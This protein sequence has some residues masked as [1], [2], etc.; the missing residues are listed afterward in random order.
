[1]TTAPQPQ[2]PR[3]SWLRTL[4]FDNPMLFEATR[5][6]RRFVRT[7]GDTGRAV[8]FTVLGIL[9]IVYL[10]LLAAI[11]RWREDMSAM[12]LIFEALV[13]TLGVPASMYAAVSGEREKLTWD[14]L[15]MTRLTPAQV[16]AGKL[17]WRVALVFAISLLFLPPLLLGHAYGKHEQYSLSGLIQAQAALTAWGLLLAAFSLYV[18]ACTR[19]G[20]TTL[21]LL[22]GSLLGFLIV[23]PGLFALF[24]GD[25]AIKSGTPLEY[26]GALFVHLNPVYRLVDLADDY[27]VDFLFW[28]DLLGRDIGVD[29]ALPLLYTLGAAVFTKLSWKR[30]KGMEL[31]GRKAR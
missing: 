11:V 17:L 30:L 5:V 15:L 13:F 3:A 9:V 10:W 23:V 1:M 27:H 19:R 21:S 28:R 4:V 25:P 14:A 20:V 18:S 24:G 7:G 12:F 16:V 31:P 29:S 6:A 8:N 2:H 22:S 26:V